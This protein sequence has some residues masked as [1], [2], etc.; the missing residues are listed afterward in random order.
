[1]AQNYAVG[2]VVTHKPVAT[3][4]GRPAAQ[5]SGGVQEAIIQ[6]A[7]P[8]RAA[9][10]ARDDAATG[11][12]PS[13]L[14]CGPSRSN[15]GNIRVNQDC[16][17]RRQAEEQITVDPTNPNHLIAGQNDS[18]V[19]YNKCGFD[20]SF[21]GGRHW[22]DGIP[23]FYQHT[24]QG[25]VNDPETR[26]GGPAGTGH[27][28]D[29]ASDP[30]LTFDSAGNAYFSCVV[31]DV[32]SAASGLFVTASTGGA[33]GSAYANIPDRASAPY[34]VVE[35]N[36]PAIFNDKEFIAADAHPASP[37]RDNVYVTW[38]RFK[39]NPAGQCVSPI[40]FSRSTDQAKTWSVP[41]EISGN[42]AALCVGGNLVHGVPGTADECNNS[43]GSS[44]VVGPDGTISVAFN[45]GNVPV[46][47]QGQQLFVQSHDGGKTWSKPSRIGSDDLFSTIDGSPAPT[48]D[49]GR[50]PEECVPAPTDVR[51]N[52]YPMLTVDSTGK[53]LAATWEDF[54]NGVKSNENF[55]IVLATSTD[56]GANWSS[57]VVFKDSSQTAQFEP[58]VAINQST[59]A[60]AVSYYDRSVNNDAVTGKYDYSISLGKS[61]TGEFSHRRVSNVS[62]LSPDF[63]P[64][65]AGFLGDY[66]S[67]AWSGKDALPMW[68]DGRNLDPL[69][70]PDEDVFVARIPAGESD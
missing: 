24:N 58:A 32:N 61:A 64:A 13:A 19:G 15:D 63:N 1:M 60:V 39:C 51:T 11:P 34:V 41:I 17:V 38:S 3:I 56:G 31:F 48:C 30:A 53:V 46:G 66:S 6:L 36:D 62:A 50:G 25:T 4:N 27:T 47:A 23:P 2:A 35:N 49:F 21:D 69:G 52:D 10:V 45:N 33:S 42:N 37:F 44:P 22:G 65:Q 5:L 9:A 43:Q 12:T 16:T 70:Q 26:K 68:S 14:G 59:G 28:Y 7:S 29:A 8:S 55:D 18:R 40:F 57:G 54:R 67:V 20:Y